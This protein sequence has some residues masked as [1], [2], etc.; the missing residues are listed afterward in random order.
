[1]WIKRM[2]TTA[3]SK[4][5][6]VERILHVLHPF[7]RVHRKIGILPAE[8]SA[9]GWRPI[10]RLPWRKSGPEP[11]R[12]SGRKFVIIYSRTTLRW[13][14]FNIFRIRRR[15]APRNRGIILF[16]IQ[17]SLNF[18]A[19]QNNNN[20]NNIRDEHERRRRRRR[21]NHLRFGKLFYNNIHLYLS[22]QCTT[23]IMR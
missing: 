14:C 23:C 13:Y 16:N 18:F 4:I 3:T 5:E 1:M 20:S 19:E 12:Q 11:P 17:R 9:R 6:L 21:K 22:K 8:G 7:S 15:R 10:P 2:C